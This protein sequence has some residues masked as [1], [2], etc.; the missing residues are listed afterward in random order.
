MYVTRSPLPTPRV[1]PVDP[2]SQRSK[3]MV[4]EHSDITPSG[5]NA[6]APH[7]T[8][9][10]PPGPLIVQPAVVGATLPEDPMAETKDDIPSLQSPPPATQPSLYLQPTVFAQPSQPHNTY[11]YAP[12]ATQQAYPSSNSQMMP[13]QPFPHAGFPS[14]Q[15]HVV[16][17]PSVP[18][19]PLPS[20]QSPMTQM[21]SN[22]TSLNGP[23]LQTPNLA[24]IMTIMEVVRHMDHS[25]WFGQNQLPV[26]QLPANSNA[27]TFSAQPP[28][29][30]RPAL[31]TSSF[32][33]TGGFESFRVDASL[34]SSQDQ[35][36][37]TATSSP[38]HG[39]V[40]EVSEDRSMTRKSRTK[41]ARRPPDEVLTSPI[42]RK[43]SYAV[44][45]TNP[46][47]KRLRKGKEKAISTDSSDHSEG[48]ELIEASD[49]S[50]SSRSSASPPAQPRS[51][52][53]RKKHGEIFLSGSGQPLR[54]FVQVDLH[55]RHTVV[56]NIKVC[57]DSISH[58]KLDT[59]GL[60][61]KIRERLL[62][63]LQMPTI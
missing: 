16:H 52:I 47:P 4:A 62:T 26:S 58:R 37:D 11:A 55:G 63:I 61:R 20:V 30:P 10:P 5:S 24:T 13:T 2:T 3:N 40:T 6:S 39:C 19:T 22:M 9:L 35:L 54:F 56:T 29:T 34:S 8:K 38:K 60:N 23:N 14:S 42:S 57:L 7:I 33:A 36:S 18:H 50:Y 15:P 46:P 53:A 31:S 45:P 59:D 48:D 12:F 21:T 27:S 17:A 43:R 1:T 49:I 25:S 41:L 44:K 28:A 51:I 32:Q